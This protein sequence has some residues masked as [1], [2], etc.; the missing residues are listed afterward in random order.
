MGTLNFRT[1]NEA[2]IECRIA[3]VKDSNNLV[4]RNATRPLNRV[5]GLVLL[6]T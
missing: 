1:L 6:F 5:R 2:E 4:V 3:T